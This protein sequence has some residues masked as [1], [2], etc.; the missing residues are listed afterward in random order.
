MSFAKTAIAALTS[1]T[2]IVVPTVAS[3]RADGYYAIKADG[4]PKALPNGTMPLERVSGTPDQ[5]TIRA[6]VSKD[7]SWRDC[8]NY[9][10]PRT[11][12]SS[13]PSAGPENTSSSEKCNFDGDPSHLLC[14]EGKVPLI[15]GFCYEG[16][17]MTFAGAMSRYQFQP[18]GCSTETKEKGHPL[19]ATA[20]AIS[21]L[22]LVA[23]A[24]NVICKGSHYYGY[25]GYTYSGPGFSA[26]NGPSYL[27]GFGY[28]QMCRNNRPC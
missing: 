26:Q 5:N 14:H 16:V 7:D 23:C 10:D 4:T 20:I 27:S 3:A 25:G 21:T 1:L 12:G 11:F 2:L 13:A 18:Q 17:V 28:Y 19:L 9:R 6:C 22:G 15:P 8:G 24:A